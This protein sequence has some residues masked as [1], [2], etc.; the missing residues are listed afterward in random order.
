MFFERTDC[1]VSILGVFRLNRGGYRHESNN[2]RAY[3][4]LSIRTEGCAEFQSEG[5][6]LSICPGDVLYIPEKARYF[7][8]TSGETIYAVHFVDYN[9]QLDHLEVMTPEQP[10]KVQELMEKM[11]LEWEGRKVGYQYRTACLF[12]TLLELLSGQKHEELVHTAA[13]DDRLSTAV[14]HMYKNFRD[15]ELTVKILAEKVSYSEVYF[16]KLFLRTFGVQPKKYMINLRLEYAQ[17]LLSSG[18]YGVQ[19]VALMSG[20]ENPK[21]FSTAFHNKYGLS[22]KEYQNKHS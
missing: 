11:W 6:T 17:Q 15:P 4:T 9:S 20:F 8:K 19:E 1:A 16:R 2:N 22:P 3:D 14:R 18:F 12:Y 13:P 21:Y 10:E 5:K 7:Q